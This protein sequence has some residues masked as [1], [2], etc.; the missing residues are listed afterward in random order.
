MYNAVLYQTAYRQ[1]TRK[2]REELLAIHKQ[3]FSSFGD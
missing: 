1:Q 3:F 2:R